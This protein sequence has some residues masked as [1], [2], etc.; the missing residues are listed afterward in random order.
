MSDSATKASLRSPIRP[1][2]PGDR[3][4]DVLTKGFVPKAA[5]GP[6]RPPRVIPQHAPA[7]TPAA[8]TRGE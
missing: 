1:L 5:G 3:P 4:G 7:P 8:K 2:T 6:V